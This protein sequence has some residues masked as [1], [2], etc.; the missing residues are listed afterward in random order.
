MRERKTVT[1][2]NNLPAHIIEECPELVSRK[3]MSNEKNPGPV[4]NIKRNTV[5]YNIGSSLSYID[6]PA[7]ITNITMHMANIIG[8]RQ[9]RN[10]IPSM[11]PRLHITSAKIT[12]MSDTSLPSDRG[13]GNVIINRS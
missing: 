6:P 13:S 2:K 10:R 11:R 1:K 9:K 5:R 7:C 4:K 8:M 3:A 12:R